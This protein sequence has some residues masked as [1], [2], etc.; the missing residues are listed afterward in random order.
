LDSIV[1][2]PNAG[3]IVLHLVHGTWPEGGWLAHHFPRFRTKKPLWFQE[4]SEFRKDIQAGLRIKVEFR[5]LLWS[6]RNS[7]LARADAAEKLVKAL[8]SAA[9]H[10]R[11]NE[12]HYVIAHSH[13]G[14]VVTSAFAQLPEAVRSR[15]SGIVTMGTPFL[16][17]EWSTD[18]AAGTTEIALGC[19]SV[20][21][22]L[23]VSA[24]VVAALG[25]L[26]YF[27]LGMGEI[28][29]NTPWW[30]VA[31]AL[32]GAVAGFVLWA[33]WVETAKALARYLQLDVSVIL[34]PMLV[35]RAPGDEAGLSLAAAEI[36]SRIA[37]QVWKTIAGSTLLFGIA[38]IPFV[39]LAE[40]LN[41]KVTGDGLALFPALLLALVFWFGGLGVIGVAI[42][43]SLG[44]V[45]SLAFGPEALPLF[46]LT[47]L[48][49]E[50]APGGAQVQ[51]IVLKAQAR[52]ARHSVPE[53][54]ESRRV[55]TEWLRAHST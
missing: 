37:S 48:G 51:M 26:V 25:A 52:I 36:V 22:G 13:G 24:L 50:T 34:P 17:S 30:M 3:T 39:I 47:K 21:V 4:G 23:F 29:D 41:Y 27:L 28:P 16:N 1:N 32:V 18:D 11:E 42:S 54:V 38:L 40:V 49:A 15:I 14:N 8:R 31:A 2:K 5:V 7:F 35:M 44:V 10:A 53:L 20:V 9:E 43:L 45:A 19:A 46:L 55:I 12:Q 33:N 6:G